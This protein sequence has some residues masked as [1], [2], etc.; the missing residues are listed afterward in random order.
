MED[1]DCA[2][3]VAEEDPAHKTKEDVVTQEKPGT[4][5]GERDDD[6]SRHELS[7]SIIT[8]LVLCCMLLMLVEICDLT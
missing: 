2:I 7:A 3:G 1:E 5:G 4:P 8:T 6:R